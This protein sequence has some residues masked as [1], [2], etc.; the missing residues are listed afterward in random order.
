MHKPEPEQKYD[1]A[2][3]FLAPDEPIASALDQELRK[4]LSVFFFPRKQDELAGTD[5]MET[6]RKPFLNA[7]VMVVL[8]RER[9]GKTKWTAIEEMAVKESCFNG[10]WN[11]LMFVVLDKNSKIPGW[12]PQ[13]HVR[14]N[15]EDFGEEQ[16]LGAIKSRAVENGSI[17]TE[18]TP[19][20][21]AEQ[22]KADDLYRADKS[23]MDTFEGI[24]AILRE[25]ETL[26]R[27]IERQCSEVNSSYEGQIQCEWVMKPREI[28]Q[29]CVLTDGFV[30]MVVL[31][32]QPYTN[33]L[34]KSNLS[35]KQ[36]NQGLILPSNL[37]NRVYVRHPEPIYEEE[38][39][40]ELS[41]SRQYG[42]T[43]DDERF[44]SSNALAKRVVIQ[45]IE[46]KDLR[47]AG[48]LSSDD[49]WF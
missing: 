8:Y 2:I 3:S 10:N 16:L 11:R 12:I 18:L 41:R 6:M 47:A 46:L 1:V 33:T 24:A 42:W 38:F 30:G 35:I 17:P 14:Y 23:Q 5:G 36:Y 4:S 43:K 27:E 15:Y 48:S 7:N 45:F 34:S 21:R 31:W 28:D 37:G 22:L 25:V 44:M 39:K 9:W 19:A 26:F 20:K 49:D 13:S 29:S 32:T 40:P